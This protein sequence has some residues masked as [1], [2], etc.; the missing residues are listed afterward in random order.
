[1]ETRIQILGSG[2]STG[3]P[4]P[5][6]SCPVCRSTDPKNRRTRSSVF[7]SW[8]NYCLLIDTA[9]EF[10]LQALSTG[11]TRLDAVLYTHAHADHM[12]GFDDL[13]KFSWGKPDGLHLY[14]STE[15]MR[16]IR[17]SFG[18]AFKRRRQEGGGV[19]RV[20]LKTISSP[21]ELGGRTVVPLPVYHGKIPILGYRLGNIAYLT[22]CSRVP[23]ET[24][25]RLTGLE[26]LIL[27]VLRYRPH[28]TH[29]HL[30][31]ALTLINQIKP[32]RAVF[33]HLAHDFDYERT[34]SEL[35][36]GVELAYD[37]LTIVI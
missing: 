21:F 29:L 34:K 20:K 7:I 5:C 1:M 6:C 16:Q 13:R 25:E 36:L 28:S 11:L 15:T 33:T 10:R 18:Y 22:D 19:P 12:A 26:L 4:E 32:R 2:T 37:G 24:M 23:P 8:D 31:A 9:P 35:P 14:G 27:G 30:D 3:V 17:R